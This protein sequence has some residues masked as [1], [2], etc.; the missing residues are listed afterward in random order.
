MLK[1][2]FKN[3]FVLIMILILII[4][5]YYLVFSCDYLV[6]RITYIDT[7]VMNS[8]SF[9]SDIFTVIMKIFTFIGSFYIPI[10]ILIILYCF[11]SKRKDTYFLTIVY[12]FSGLVIFMCKYLI[13]RDRPV[14]ALIT[15]PFTP[16]FPSGHSFTSMVFYFLL[17]YII[18]N[19]KSIKYKM[20]VLALFICI[21][22]IVGFSRI[23]LGVHYFSDVIGGFILSI[24]VILIALNSYKLLI[25]EDIK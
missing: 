11:K 17:G 4:I 12:I 22:L 3:N 14:S 1:R 2:V 9:D 21:S 23:F 7:I 20:I 25:K 19:N 8:I 16:S 10:L 18:S 13:S 6:S 15:I 5:G 24:P